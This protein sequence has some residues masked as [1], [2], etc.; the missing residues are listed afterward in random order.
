[1]ADDTGIFSADELAAEAVQR[2]DPPPEQQQ[3][4]RDDRPRDEHGR[5]APKQDEQQ[6]AAPAE[7]EQRDD[8]GNLVPQGAMHAERE[9]RKAAEKELQT[10][11]EQLQRIAAM[12]EAAA[13]RRT[14]AEAGQSAEPAPEADPAAH[15]E[16]LKAKLAEIEGT[17]NQFV[18][19]RQVESLNQAET[20][21]LHTVLS[22]S[23]AE[24]RQQK[25]D[26]DEA[27]NHVVQA[28]A[29]ELKLYGLTPVQIQQHLQEEVLDITRSA[30]AQGRSPAEIGYEIALLR[31]YT[32]G[33]APTNAQPGGQ[34][35][36]GGGAA[37]V[38][39]IAAAQKGSRSLGQASGAAP[40]KDLNAQ[41]IASM[42]EEEFD[43]L[44]STPEGRR[45]IDNL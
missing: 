40:P 22:S 21:Q 13:A 19:E 8:K 31:G 9:R 39:A 34:G 2:N 27:I 24:L 44:Y 36:N 17:Q 37:R 33:E 23:E 38:A 7:Q 42:S 32:P 20:Q 14:A 25:P 12:R 18:Q 5:F 4:Q 10:A 1:M 28:R 35:S 16:Y 3:E 41:T 26:Y 30:I 11:R 6:Q 15:I 45:M 29:R 43:A